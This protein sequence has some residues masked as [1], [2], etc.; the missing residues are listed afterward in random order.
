VQPTLLVKVLRTLRVTFVP[1]QRSKF[2]GASK[3]H[4]VV[5]I[6]VLLVGQNMPGGIVSTTVTV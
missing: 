5:H 2:V 3:A 6:T 4:G 1:Q